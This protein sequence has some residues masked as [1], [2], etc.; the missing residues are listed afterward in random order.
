MTNSEKQF[1]SAQASLL[2]C[3][4]ILLSGLLLW[5]FRTQS[6]DSMLTY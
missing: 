5:A 3:G 2:Q 1:V 6:E 4:L